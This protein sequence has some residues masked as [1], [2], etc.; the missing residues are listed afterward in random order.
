MLPALT[1][2][3]TSTVAL[4]APL[5][6]IPDHPPTAL[7]A[8]RFAFPR[9]DGRPAV[10]LQVLPAVVLHVPPGG[11]VPAGARSLGGESWLL[12]ATDPAAAVALAGQLHGRDGLTA[13]PD[14]VLPI[15][16]TQSVPGADDPGRGGQ[17]YL[18]DLDYD[19]LL[20]LTPGDPSTRVAVIDSGIDISHPDLS[21]AYEAPY[22]AFDDDDDPSPN[23][24]EYCS[25]SSTD[26]CDE[27]GTAVSGIVLA[28]ADNGD[29]IV[30]MCPACTLIP[31]KLLG[32]AGLNDNTLSIDVRAYEH[33]IEQ[34]VSVINNS[35]GFTEAI[36][37][38]D[39]LAEVIHRAA[40]ETRGGLG[41]LV[42]F[43]AGN[44]DREI[45]P[46]ELQALDDVL[47]VSAMDSYGNPTNYTN[48]GAAVELAAPS[49]TVTIAPGDTMIDDFGGTSAAAPVASGLASWAA[50]V[51]PTLSAQ[52]LMAVMLETA[53]PSP[54]VSFDAD[55]HNDYYGYGEIDAIAVMERVWVE[56][57][58]TGG[59]QPKATSCTTVG[60]ADVGLGAL[61][62]SLLV[63]VG[64]GRRRRHRA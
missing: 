61:S 45:E 15:Q 50:S 54:R 60:A 55:G 64:G 53:H 6:M 44:D 46:D 56:P 47:C 63:L 35:W 22:D 42:I 49:A 5:S 59:E 20:A 24:G 43:A 30:G 1:L 7:S 17:W 19:Q 52:D 51:A 10:D 11:A 40:T 28:R 62:L 26:I 33:A 57:A 32:E 41:S 48:F 4:G 18:D 58:D 31:I 3:V 38:P 14:V 34:D 13:F 25:G 2:I 36:P 27:H 23:P 8:D 12:S 21:T 37:V 39:N 29:G 9:A 16:R